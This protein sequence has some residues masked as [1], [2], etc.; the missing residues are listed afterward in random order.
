MTRSLSVALLAAVML[1]AMPAAAQ[2][3]P[4]DAQVYVFL[5][6]AGPSWKAGRPMGEQNL[7]AHAAYIKKLLDDGRLFAGGPTGADT[8]LAIVRAAN[9]EEAQT[10]LSADPA[11]TTGV[12]IADLRRW[13]PAFDS[14]KPL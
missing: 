11:I 4:A 7:G 5:Y 6:R 8:G 14:K 13:T 9:L 12:F 3:A 2:T 10:M 1:L